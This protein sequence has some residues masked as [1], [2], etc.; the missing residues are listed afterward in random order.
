MIDNL[1]IFHLS[2][3]NKTLVNKKAFLPLTNSEEEVQAL[4]YSGSMQLKVYDE[5]NK[6]VILGKRIHIVE[7]KKGKM[8]V[9]IPDNTIYGTRSLVY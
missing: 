1:V 5:Y 7:W 9:Y 2:S 6:K 4:N 3:S 8:C